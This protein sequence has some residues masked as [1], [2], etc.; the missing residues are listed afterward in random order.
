MA[1]GNNTITPI[2]QNWFTLNSSSIS[3]LDQ[4]K[5]EMKADF[6]LRKRREELEKLKARV[7]QSKGIA[8]LANSNVN[9]SLGASSNPSANASNPDYFAPP[10]H[11]ISSPLVPIPIPTT[12]TAPVSVPVSAERDYSQPY[13]H[14]PCTQPQPPQPRFVQP[15]LPTQPAQ[16][17]QPAQFVNPNAVGQVGPI[18][19]SS[20]GN[21]NPPVGVPTGASGNVNANVRGQDRVSTPAQDP[22]RFS[23]AHLPPPPPEMFTPSPQT[24]S[25]A[26]SAA[27]AH[28]YSS[29]PNSSNSSLNTSSRAEPV[30]QLL[31]SFDDKRRISASASANDRGRDRSS[32]SGTKGGKGKKKKKKEPKDIFKQ[33]LGLRWD[34]IIEQF[35]EA[36]HQRQR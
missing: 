5:I 11:F 32:Q 6:D 28:S 30:H 3:E 13:P 26:S 29:Y 15:Q 19:S 23:S 34:L 24:M 2:T 9:T 12:T 20:F 21:P 33:L 10:H 1:D 27:T 18:T 22:R 16:S 36:C 7:A 14:L 25:S 17:M 31:Q 4:R 35:A 8:T